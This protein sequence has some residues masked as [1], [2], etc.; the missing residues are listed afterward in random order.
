MLPLMLEAAALLEKDHPGIEIFVS[1]SP[2][3]PKKIYD[4]FLDGT[5]A[6]LYDGSLVS[7]LDECDMAAVTSGT[8]TLQTA[9]RGLP[10][11]IVYKTSAITFHIVKRA[12]DIKWIGLPNIIAQKSIVPELIQDDA[13]A[14]SLAAVFEN[15]ISDSDEYGAISGALAKLRWSLG[16]KKAS[17]ELAKIIKRVS[18]LEDQAS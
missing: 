2:N 3:Q 14:L 6:K 10:H 15:W 13:T 16:E 4:K 5:D 17:V 12:V 1:K 18:G 8:A 7:M 9:L 11:A